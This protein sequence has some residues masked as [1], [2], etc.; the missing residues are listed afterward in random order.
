MIFS[1]GSTSYL[2]EKNS[3]WN[4]LSKEK[5]LYFSKFGDIF[6][7][8][9]FKNKKNL[10][11]INLLFVNDLINLGT[12][13][14]FEFKKKN[15]YQILKKL[16]Y[17]LENTERPIIV[18]ISDYSYNN[19]IESAQNL[20]IEKKIK[21]FFLNELYNLT[22]K[23]K[24]LYILDIDE[25]F[26]IHGL[27]K[28][29]D[30]RN[31]ILSRCRI[32]SLGIEVIAK[33]LKKI[34]N[35]IFKSNK[36]ALLL[37]CD[38]T[39]WGGVIAEDGVNKIKIGEEGEGLAFLEFQKAIK[40]LQEQGVLII[41]LSKNIEADVFKV[42]KTHSGMVLKKRDIS[43]HKINW[44]EKSKNI[45]KIS[46]DLD[47]S[48]DSFVFW[49]D[50]PIE[51]E[52]V[53]LKLR[54]VEVIE[55]DQDVSNWAKQLLEYDGFS[56]FNITD[57]DTNRTKQYQTRQKFIDSKANYKNEIDYLSS[58][59]IKAK[60]ID[61]NNKNVD[62]AA[63]MCQRTNQFNF[64]TKRYNHKDL[65]K[66]NKNYKCFMVQLKDI[67]GDHGIISFI[68]LK[69]ISKKIILIDTFLMSCRVLGRYLE[70]WILKNIVDLAKQNKIKVILAEFVKKEKNSIVK[71]FLKKNNFK[72]NF[73][74]D[75]SKK[76]I[77]LSNG[78]FNKKS[79]LFIYDL[80]NRIE[81]LKIYEKK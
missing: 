27:E 30:N 11:Y 4:Y 31:Y 37:D 13:K 77:L 67:Y 32:S 64:S 29:F 73:K 28:C 1:L 62:R 26:S 69:I 2:L 68:C 19:I 61:L 47:L 8:K 33:N 21:S 16:K 70:N 50:N 72:K 20:K 60:L 59:K 74:N 3:G 38:N 17:N 6:S 12:S 81:N 48:L 10:I 24:N 80:N 35:R 41:L 40:K 63:Q 51:R 49:D 5:N 54:A 57:N 52:K 18:G 66:L 53:K 56:K 25:I 22:K 75:F 36:K 42:F 65:L 58:I 71:D 79:E 39:L 43:A 78:S 45:L 34:A 76:E 55:P 23:Y 7:I 44:Y 14:N 9:E 15:F 46:T